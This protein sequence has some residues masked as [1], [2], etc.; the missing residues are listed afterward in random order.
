MWQKVPLTA[1]HQGRM[2]V[3]EMGERRVWGKEALPECQGEA[4]GSGPLRLMEKRKKESEVTQ[5]CPT[6]CNPMDFSLPGS[7]VHGI[8]QAKILGGLPFPSPG[9]LPNPGIEPGSPSLQAML[10]RLSHQGSPNE[11]NGERC[12]KQKQRKQMS[13]LSSERSGK[14]KTMLWC[15]SELMWFRASLLH[16]SGLTFLEYWFP[17]SW[18]RE[19]PRAEM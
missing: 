19:H 17:I 14:H 4:S 3:A 13:W 6:L 9:D 1:K 10:Y 2:G 5:L 15:D 8:F 7:S 11:A 12:Q 16:Q 18:N